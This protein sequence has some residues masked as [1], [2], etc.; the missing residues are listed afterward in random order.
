MSNPHP[1]H[2]LR[3]E[4]LRL[5]RELPIVVS[6]LAMNEFKGNFR[7]QG[8]RTDGQS[9]DK[10]KKRKGKKNKR[11]ILTKS[12]RLKRSF[13]IK[14]SL[15]LAKVVNN[16]PYAK[17]HNEGFKGTVKVKKH[18]RAGM[19]KS[20]EGTGVFSIKTKKEKMR[21]VKKATG[22]N[23]KVKSHSRKMDLPARP[24]MKTTKALIADIDKKIDERL[25]KIF[26]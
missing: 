26:K 10:W 2:K 3:A 13:K 25:K 14:P 17:A 4:F 11:P 19:K 8:L 23:H 6:N 21:G 22:K 20:Q 18:T 1:F 9:V 7:R 16:A 15:G 5:Y 24:F 12:G